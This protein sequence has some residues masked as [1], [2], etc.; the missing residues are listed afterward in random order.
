MTKVP[1]VGVKNFFPTG[2]AE[3]GLRAPRCSSPTFDL[4]RIKTLLSNGGSSRVQRSQRGLGRSGWIVGKQ[5][6]S[7]SQEKWI[8]SV[9]KKSVFKKP[10]GSVP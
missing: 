6:V 2:K 3:M 8:I 5:E 4:K 9:F 10:L 1:N 7:N